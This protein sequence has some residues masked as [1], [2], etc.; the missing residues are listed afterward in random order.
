MVANAERK[1]LQ[2]DAQNVADYFRT[3]DVRHDITVEGHAFRLRPIGDPDAALV[4]QLRNDTKLNRYLHAGAPDVP[5]QLK[6]FS[7][8]YLRA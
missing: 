7:Q 8:Y 1:M 5:A 3:L 2:S 4:V 6:W